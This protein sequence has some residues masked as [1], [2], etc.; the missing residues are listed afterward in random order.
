MSCRATGP[1]PLR[2][3]ALVQLLRVTDDRRA[4]AE[5]LLAEWGDEMPL[6]VD[7]VLATP[8]LLLGT[9]AEIADQLHE[10]SERFGIDTWTVFAGRR[11]TPASRTSAAVAEPSLADSGPRS[12]WSVTSAHVPRAR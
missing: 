4:A 7:E 3:Q 5:Q 8:F 11:S 9:A 2:F 12:R 10:R 1:E 6:S